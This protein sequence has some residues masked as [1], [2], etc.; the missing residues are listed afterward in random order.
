MGWGGRRRGGRLLHRPCC[1]CCC[2]PPPAAL[3]SLRFSLGAQTAPRASTS[4]SPRPTPRRGR[5]WV[6]SNLSFETNTGLSFFETVIRLLAG[7]VSAHHLSG[8]AVFR[9][10]AVDLADRLLPVFDT[11]SGIPDNSAALPRSSP[12]GGGGVSCLAEIGT[13]TIEFGSITALTGDK[14]YGL[15][16]E[17]GLRF[18]HAAHP[19]KVGSRGG[20]RA[21]EGWGPRRSWAVSA[22]DRCTRPP[23]QPLACLT[24]PSSTRSLPFVWCRP[25]PPFCAGPAGNG[26]AAVGRGRGQ[27]AD[28]HRGKRRQVSGPGAGFRAD[29]EGWWA[30]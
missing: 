24:P 3:A 4:L 1:C 23:P 7:L 16:A 20:G 2:C 8:E 12:S 15:A 21:G 19:T 14:K 18:L 10:K 9:E 25:H 17:K 6:V 22:G 11:P 30:G 28:E 29:V 5:D 13:D 27:L 26:C